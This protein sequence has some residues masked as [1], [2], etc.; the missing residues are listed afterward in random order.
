VTIEPPPR[1]HFEGENA[2]YSTFWLLLLDLVS[3]F[4]WI[5]V[6]C[7]SAIF[8]IKILR[9][10][11]GE[12]DLMTSRIIFL[13]LLI[14]FALMTTYSVFESCG[15]YHVGLVPIFAL[16]SAGAFKAWRVPAVARS[17]SMSGLESFV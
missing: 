16:L 15:E 2:K 8:I 10:K 7:L 4:Y 6:L 9:V 3:H 13:S 11:I 17:E 1:V 12:R 14:F 5:L